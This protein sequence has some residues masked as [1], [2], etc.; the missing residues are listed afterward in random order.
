MSAVAVAGMT[1]NSDE[2][3]NSAIKL[4]REG[5]WDRAEA[6]Y[7]ALLHSDPHDA[8]A[9]HLLGLIDFQRGDRRG[10]LNGSAGRSN[11]RA[12]IPSTTAT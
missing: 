12:K 9:W 1:G 5:H 2:Q 3:L 4:H 10:P 11:S 6:I 8:K 7:Q